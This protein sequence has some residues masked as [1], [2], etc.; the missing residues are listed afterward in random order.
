[1]CFVY[2]VI[3]IADE[4]KNKEIK[5]VYKTLLTFLRETNLITVSIY[6]ITALFPLSSCVMYAPVPHFHA[7]RMGR[8]SDLHFFCPKT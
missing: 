3:N 7:L 6:A 5:G 8:Y 1:M 2:D 4:F